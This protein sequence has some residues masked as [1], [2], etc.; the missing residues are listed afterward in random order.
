MA[1]FITVEAALRSPA[2]LTAQE[3]PGQLPDAPGGWLEGAKAALDVEDKD[4]ISV[5]AH[6][7]VRAHTLYLAQPEI[8]GWLFDLRNAVQDSR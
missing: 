3:Q 2:V 8:K 4:Q 6:T 1:Q 7:I 5:E